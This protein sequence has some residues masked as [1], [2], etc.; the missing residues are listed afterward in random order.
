MQKS[1]RIKLIIFDFD[2]CIANSIPLAVRIA[3]ELAPKYLKIKLDFKHVMYHEG[4]Q[5]LIKKSKSRPWKVLHLV[6]RFRK[7]MARRFFTVKPYPEIVHVIKNLSSYYSIGLVTSNSRKN[8]KLF[9][10]KHGLSEDFRFVRANVS[11]FMKAWRIKRILRK[12]KLKKSEAVMIGDE[13]RDMIAARK[14]GIHSI[15]VT[16]GVN[17]KKLLAKEK[18]DFIVSSPEQLLRVIEKL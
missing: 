17:S 9:L 3:E 10:R 2:G 5:A 14:T 8:A 1:S 15:A 16:W 13:T 4:M 11:L 18:P 12:Y 6:R 7:M